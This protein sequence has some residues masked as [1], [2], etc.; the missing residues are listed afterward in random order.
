M[1]RLR[2]GDAVLSTRTDVPFGRRRSEGPGRVS[3]VHWQHEV[4]TE[5]PLS[6]WESDL[7]VAL[8]SIVRTGEG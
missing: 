5:E 7:V 4:V 8:L 2:L 6:D 3:P 1:R